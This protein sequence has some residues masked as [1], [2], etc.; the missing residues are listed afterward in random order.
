MGFRTGLLTCLSTLG[1]CDNMN[2]EEAQRLFNSDS[3]QELSQDGD[4]LRFLKLR[5]LNRKEHLERL[6]QT[7]GVSLSTSAARG[8]FRQAY[9]CAETTSP[10]LDRLIRDIYEAER[11]SRRQAEPDL[12]NN[13]YRL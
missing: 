12:V 3:I 5:S 6:F 7:V 10:V 1:Q 13:L 4:G 2:F 11:A 8:M 9:E